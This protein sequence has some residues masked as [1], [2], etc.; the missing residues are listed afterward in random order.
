[1]IHL[2]LA[3][4]LIALSTAAILHAVTGGSQ[5]RPLL[6]VRGA[7]LAVGAACLLVVCLVNAVHP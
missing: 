6:I 3:A 2:L 4:A 7:A 5:Y 1:M